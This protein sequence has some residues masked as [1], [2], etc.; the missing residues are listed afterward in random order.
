MKKTL[1]SMNSML[2]GLAY[3]N[4]KFRTC[5][6]T[7]SDDVV[8]CLMIYQIKADGVYITSVH[9]GNRSCPWDNGG[10]PDY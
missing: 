9:V 2:S 1:K 3:K 5:Y 8:N 4:A 6:P 7:G 10:D